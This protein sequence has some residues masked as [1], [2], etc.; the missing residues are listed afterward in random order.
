ME[1]PARL[2]YTRKEWE[3][4]NE[5][6]EDT[7]LAALAEG[8]FQ[9][10]ELAKLYFPGGT[11]IESLDYEEALAQTNALLQKKDAVIYEAAVGF[12][13]LFIRADILVKKGDTLELIEVKAKSFDPEESKFMGKQGGIA[14]AW[15]AYLHDVAFQRHV[16]SGAFPR[17]KVKAYLMLADKS[18]ACPSD[19]LHQKFR[20]VKESGGAVGTKRNQR[21]VV[22]PLSPL[23]AKERILVQI[24]VD[25]ECDLI[26]K[27]EL[28]VELGPAAF[29]DRIQWLDDHYARD[30]KIARS[31]AGK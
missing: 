21:V 14:S 2:F 12:G 3:Y 24:N 22:K 31:A 15:K 13:T 5:N 16:I 27:S 11:D 17:F 23:E 28:D 7:F 30:E 19:G 10:G 4:A 20:I 8:G 9:V 1:C 25:R 6:L 29:V 26:L 18:A